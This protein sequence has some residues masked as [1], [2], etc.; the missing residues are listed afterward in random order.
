MRG[1]NYM[2][3]CPTCKSEFPD[4]FPLEENLYKFKCYKCGKEIC[5]ECSSSVF[6][7]EEKEIVNYC[8]Y[9]IRDE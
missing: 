7:K 5:G 9:C 6:S 1:D 2:Y 8:L 4:N 3:Q